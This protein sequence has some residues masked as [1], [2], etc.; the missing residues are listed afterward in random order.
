M[1]EPSESYSGLHPPTEPPV[2]EP[3][4]FD[5][6]PDWDVFEDE[7]ECP[8]CGYNLRGLEHAKCPE[9]GSLFLWRDL[10]DPNRRMHESL[11]EYHNGSTVKGFAASLFAGINPIRFWESIHPVL[12]IRT[13]RLRTYGIL[14]L[15]MMVGSFVMGQ[16][17][18]A[19]QRGRWW[20]GRISG[21]AFFPWTWSRRDFGLVLAENF[22]VID[23]VVW[24]VA[25]IGAMMVF[26]DTMRRAKI[27]S[28]HVFRCAVYTADIFVWLACIFLM[29]DGMSCLTYFEFMAPLKWL[30]FLGAIFFASIRLLAAFW[31]YLQFPNPILTVLATQIIALLAI[32]NVHA[33]TIWM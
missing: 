31:I 10:L 22:F 29:L 6:A 3:V 1:N 19:L 14:V 30:V 13:A 9:C 8:L 18:L 15:L 7:I 12:P 23:I 26:G 25:T 27:R 4:S 32:I 5:E 21:N 16:A 17:S 28:A 2:A 11:F 24:F 20:R 33:V